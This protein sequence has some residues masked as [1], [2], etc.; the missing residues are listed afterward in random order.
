MRF[1]FL[2]LLCSLALQAVS[3]D[4]LIQNALAK[5][6][7]LES[8]EHR[9]E[10]FDAAHTLSQNFS[11]PQLTLGIADIQ[12]RDIDNRSLEPMQTTSITFAQKIPIF[13]KRD[14][15]GAQ[16]KASEASLQAKL[17]ELKVALVEAIKQSAYSIYANE[18]K[19]LITE[20][21]IQLTRQNKELSTSYTSSDVSAHM[22]IMSADLAL[23]QLKI[24]KDRLQSTLRGLY[25]QLSYLSAMD[26]EHLDLSL[27]IK[28]PL[29]L[30]NFLEHIGANTAL[31]SKEAKVKEADATLRIKELS[32]TPD[33]TLQVGYFHRESFENYLNI[34]I[35][36]SLPL[37]GSEEAEQEIARKLLLAS[38]SEVSD[39]EHALLAQIETIYAKMLSEYNTY[40]M[41]QTQSLPQIE[42]MFDLATSSIKNGA[43]LFIYFELLA[44]KLSLDEQKID[45]LA[46]Y[47]KNKATLES[48]TGALK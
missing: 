3:L 39:L 41:I 42:H 47:Y 16:T 27:S 30:E 44:Q 15:L 18:Q 40:Q 1:V 25:K 36:F 9:L 32:S 13:G 6:S 28:E 24:K 37:Y 48:L 29:D 31:Q 38:K 19:L 34:G 7:S 46:S 35:G 22:G 10:S 8:I 11:N 33:P 5:N 2:S 4:V 23:A 21:Y 43:E 17:N 12:L 26:V 45:A 20:K 14:A